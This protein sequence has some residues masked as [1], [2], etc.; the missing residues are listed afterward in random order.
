MN[1][2]TSRTVGFILVLLIAFSPSLVSAVSITE[3]SAAIGKFCVASGPYSTAMGYFTTASAIESTAMGYSTIASGP[4]ATAMGFY[5]TA[6]GFGS[7][8]I[9]YYV[10]AS[11]S[12][13]TVIGKGHGNPRLINDIPASF[14]V[15]YMGDSSDTTPELFVKDGGVGIGTTNPKDDLH[16]ADHIRVG[17]DSTYPNVYG[18][19]K[20]D[21]AGNGFRINANA[22]G[23]GWADILLQ[24]NGTTKVFVESAGNVGIG[25]TSPGY[26]LQVTGNAAKSSGGT[27][28]VVSSDVRLKSIRGKYTHG[29]HEILRLEP[30]TFHYK[31]D[32]PRDLPTDEENIGFV[33]QEVQEVFPESISE[34]PD[35]YLDFNM[36]PVNVAVVNA[37]KELKAEND[38][39]RAENAMLKKEIERIKEVLGI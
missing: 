5:S 35:G 29:L 37:I 6:S 22:G 3:K 12:Y 2:Y 39:L 26:K 32:N 1:R 21:G 18:E 13:S 23:G 19:I 33:A 27:S 16:V 17:E 7:T 11:N 15:G 28:W 25:T 24:T 8:T 10:T 4:A 36:H 38:S 20:H 14:M 31:D 34:G 30:V 9:G